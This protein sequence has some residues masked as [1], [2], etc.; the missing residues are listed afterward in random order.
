[1]QTNSIKDETG[2]NVVK[3]PYIGCSIFPEIFDL[4]HFLLENAAFQGKD[5][6]KVPD[7]LDEL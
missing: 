6:N 5:V 1:M 4:C 2:N 3:Q 7:H